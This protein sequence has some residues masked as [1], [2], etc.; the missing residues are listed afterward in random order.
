MFENA[1]KYNIRKKQRTV[2]IFFILLIILIS[3]NICIYLNVYLNKIDKMIYEVSNLSF[4]IKSINN[5]ELFL[6]DNLFKDINNVSK[7]YIYESLGSL[8]NGK[9][10]K[11]EGSINIENLNP[12]YQNVLKLHGVNTTKYL[13]EFLANVYEITEGRNILESDRF[14]I[15][16]H[17]KLKEENKYKVGDKIKLKHIKTFSLGDSL[18]KEKVGNVKSESKEFEFEIIGFFKGIGEEKYTGLSSDLSENNAYV[19]YFSLNEF[20]GNKGNEKLNK[21]SFI[22]KSKENLDDAHKKINDLIDHKKLEMENNSDAFN[23]AGE[24]ISNI[25]SILNLMNGIIFIG[26]LMAL[27][28]I[29]NLW[30][31]DRIYEIGIMI[32]IGRSKLDI[33]MQ[34]ILELLIVSIPCFVISFIFNCVLNK[35]ILFKLLNLNGVSILENL[36]ISNLKLSIYAYLCLLGIII[37]SVGISLSSIILTKPKDI[38]KKLS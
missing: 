34:F 26:G 4:S 2:I 30:I 11:S 10:Y 23:E 29:L 17:E 13:N 25:K 21:L 7:N 28:L 9:V 19:D 14:K 35:K 12:E 27:S 8:K 36:N 31:R 5:E 1:L 15:L 20:G 16:V 3:L 24:N 33:F 32:S 6:K 37:I 22:S 18:K 38:L